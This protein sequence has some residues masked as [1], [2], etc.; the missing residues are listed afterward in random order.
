MISYTMEEFQV[1]FEL[2]GGKPGYGPPFVYD[3]QFIHLG[4]PLGIT[5]I[6]WETLY[7]IIMNKGSDVPSERGL[8][9]TFLREVPLREIPHWIHKYPELARWRLRIGK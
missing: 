8:L 6:E 1:L 2:C 9:G 4:T 5:T 3:K 7:C